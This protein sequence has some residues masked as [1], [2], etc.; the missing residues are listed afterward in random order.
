[1]LNLLAKS[2]NYD[3]LE[4]SKFATQKEIRK[5]YKNLSLLFHTDKNKA[6]SAKMAFQK[7]K[8]SYDALYDGKA[9]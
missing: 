8:A 7:L 1:M 5:A 4:V 9:K 2:D 6:P 3:I